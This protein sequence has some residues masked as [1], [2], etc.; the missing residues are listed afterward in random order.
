[1][2]VSVRL[3]L[4]SAVLVVLLLLVIALGVFSSRTLHDSQEA[5]I[6]QGKVEQDALNIRFEA[7]DLNGWQTMYVW[8]ALREDSGA[9]DDGAGNRAEFLASADSFQ[10]AIK[11]VGKHELTPEQQADVDQLQSLYDDF[12]ATDEQIMAL[13]E[14][15]TQQDLNEA[16]KL[17]TV[18]TVQQYADVAAAAERVAA[19]VIA[20][21]EQINTEADSRAQGLLVFTLIVGGLA[22]VLALVLVM[23]TTRSITQPLAAMVSVLRKV[24]RGDLT[25]RVADPSPDEIGRMGVALD[26]TLDTVTGTINSIA[27][28]SGTLSAS[29]EELQA[30]SQTMGATAEET[31]QQAESVSAAAEQVSNSLQVV[32]TGAE[33]MSA[34]IREIAGSTSRAADVGAKAADV[35]RG[36]RETVMRL[37]ASSAEIGDVTRTITSIA[38]QTNLLALNA[39][40]EAARAGEAGKG[41]SVVASEVK[42]LARLTVRS[43]EE[44]GERLAAIQTE[45]EDAVEAIGQITD[46]IDQINEM[47][48]TVAAAVEEQALTAREIGRSMTDAAGGSTDIA[49]N[50]VGVAEAAQETSRGAVSTQQAATEL[51]RLAGEL[52]GLVRQFTVTE[53]AAQG[54]GTDPRSR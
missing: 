6:E 28:S 45:T 40:I 8:E 31:A 53:G 9:P 41:F 7:A 51:A 26:E 37:G 21:T 5:I 18:S 12:M 38:Q 17:T 50:I 47:Q 11:E 22:V 32:S 25:P 4:S 13:L 20:A 14:S 46:I 3:G 29:S 34:S 2:K 23:V 1:M 15:G 33:E 16:V 49:R 52:L 36:T 19:S 24:A 54:P 35:A 39:T 43:S 27:D 30:V 10:Q 44:I 42:D 48:T